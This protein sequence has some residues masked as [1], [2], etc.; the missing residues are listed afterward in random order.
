MPNH[1]EVIV[2]RQI[3]TN[4]WPIWIFYLASPLFKVLYNLSFVCKYDFSVS[5]GICYNNW[6]VLSYFNSWFSFTE[7][8]QI[9]LTIISIW[10]SSCPFAISENGYFT[11]WLVNMDRPI[12]AIRS[13][14]AQFTNDS[15][16]LMNCVQP[17]DDRVRA[18]FNCILPF[19]LNYH[20]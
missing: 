15:D 9:F 7:L 18:H 1:I 10:W 20:C 5:H 8:I 19:T 16:F 6:L 13:Y 4:I 3:D 2:S 14:I 12:S 11:I 17:I